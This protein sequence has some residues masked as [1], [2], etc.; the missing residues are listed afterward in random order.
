MLPANADTA[1]SSTFGDNVL[2]QCSCDHVSADG[3]ARATVV[4]EPGERD[5]AVGAAVAIGGRGR[6][7]LNTD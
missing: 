4:L 2:E 5:V 3:V 1:T 7:L 6:F